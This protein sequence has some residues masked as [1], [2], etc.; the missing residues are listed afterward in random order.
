[1]LWHLKMPAILVGPRPQSEVRNLIPENSL[2][3]VLL[4]SRQLRSQ[5]LLAGISHFSFFFFFF[6]RGLKAKA[7][8]LDKFGFR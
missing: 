2:H 4:L 1:M 8:E 6:L 5:V 3:S 7:L